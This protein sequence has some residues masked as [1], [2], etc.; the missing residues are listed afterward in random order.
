M[1]LFVVHWN[2][3][4]SARMLCDQHVVKM[5]SEC[6]QLLCTVHELQRERRRVTLVRDILAN[7]DVLGVLQ[8]S[9]EDLD[10]YPKMPWSPLMTYKRHP[11][12]LWLQS[13]PQSLHWLLNHARA[14]FEEYEFRFHRAHGSFSAFEEALRVKRESFPWKF[15]SKHQKLKARFW[16]WP[17]IYRMIPFC[18]VVPEELKRKPLSATGTTAAYRDYYIKEKSSFARW[19]NGRPPPDWWPFSTNRPPHGTLR[20]C[21]GKV[22]ATPSVNP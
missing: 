3:E 7:A 11:L 13:R 8:K 15:A 1:N 10:T 19:T 2:P 5:P 16:E 21:P 17:G 4:V 22:E 14:L 6:V 12:V 20:A 18:Q 9:L